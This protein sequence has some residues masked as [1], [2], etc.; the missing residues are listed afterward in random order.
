MTPAL[1]LLALF[2]EIL[3]FLAGFFLVLFSTLIF[4]LLGYET[5][6]LFLSLT[7]STMS[8]YFSMYKNSLLRGTFTRLAELLAIYLDQPAEKN[9]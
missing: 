3:N 1:S 4:L 6:Q 7:T 9:Y 2:S 8:T 5:K